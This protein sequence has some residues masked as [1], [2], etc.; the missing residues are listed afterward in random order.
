[1]SLE[2]EERE[3]ESSGRAKIDL[4]EVARTLARSWKIIVVFMGVGFVWALVALHSAP[5]VYSAQMV[6]TSVRSSDDSSGSSRFS[7]LASLAGLSMPGG[8]S[9]TQFRL[10]IE[11]IY[12]RDV[13][14]EL[15]KDPVLM[16]EL[17]GGEWDESTQSWRK[18][19]P[20]LSQ[21]IFSGIRS[22]LGLIKLPWQPP[23]GARV[24]GYLTDNIEVLQDPR[25]PFIATV[26]LHSTNP[27]FAIK[28]LNELNAAAD[29]HLR[30]EAI[31]RAQNYIAYL[32]KQLAT[33]TIAEHREALMNTL[34]EQEK[35][36][37]SAGSNVPFAAEM[38]DKPSV[39]TT[40][41]YAPRPRQIYTFW[42]FVWGVVG[43]CAVLLAKR[44]EGPLENLG[45]NLRELV[46][47]K[48]GPGNL[49]RF[50]RQS[51]RL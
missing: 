38:F 36:A 50:V 34:S 30:R 21:R 40:L 5:Y 6:V 26:K 32:T 37:M 33:V 8:Q 43:A 10:Y 29:N 3:Q 4:R 11:A 25:K 45:F 42:I 7:G 2:F 31:L 13:A 14:D 18:P 24:Q 41:L 39:D 16:K 27:K 23:S 17:F 48:V 15:A 20:S 9:A 28:I 46:L 35:Y 49:P 51:L 47:R 12:A 44:F 19:T 22:F 1:M